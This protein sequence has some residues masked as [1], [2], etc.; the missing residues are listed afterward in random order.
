MNH[1]RV[2]IDTF[3]AGLDDLTVKQAQCVDTVLRTLDRIKR[4][5]VFEASANQTIARTMTD[6]FKKGYVKDIG[7]AYPW[8]HVE[9][10]PAGRA[11][12]DAA[13][14]QEPHP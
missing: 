1:G 8:T 13:T 3:S 11:I 5:S 10:T 2:F 12:I 14:S 6:V 9:I 7:G 4:F